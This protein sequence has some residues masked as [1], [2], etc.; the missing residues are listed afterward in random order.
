[1]RNTEYNAKQVLKY[2]AWTFVIAYII[3]FLAAPL[4]KSSPQAG[5][6]VLA[7]MMFVPELGVRLSG[8]KLNGM[9]WKPQ[10]KKN[11]RPILTAWFT[12]LILT[13]AGGAL[14]FLF[15]PQHIDLSG[16]Y[17]TAL[18]GADVLELLQA[19]GVSYPVYVLIT[20]LSTITYAPLINMIAALGEEI[21]W[22]GF[23]YPQ[24]EAKFGRAKGW[25]LGSIIWGAWHWPLIWLIGYEYGEAAGNFA[26][27]AGFPVTGMLAFCVCTVGIGVLHAWLYEKS[28]TIWVPSLLHGAFN[29][30]A[31]L[32]LMLCAAD[33]GTY[34][35]LGPSP[36]GLLS[37]LPFLITA[38]YILFRRRPDAE[39]Q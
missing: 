32:P 3:Q 26:G 35:L 8:A 2:L 38:A 12:P 6:L 21:G 4:Y 31:A 18:A 9:G 19:Q 28:G 10:I 7:A 24:L 36:N 29:A 14:Y 30:V 5:Q 13:V 15:F 37:G 20:A 17:M 25:I 16:S 34:R 11:I 22:R 27:Y 23:L 39:K 1:M 33:T